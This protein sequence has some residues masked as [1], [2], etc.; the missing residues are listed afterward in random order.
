MS[1]Y[2]SFLSHLHHIYRSGDPRPF[3][4][5]HPELK[6][7]PGPIPNPLPGARPAGLLTG[8][9][10]PLDGPGVLT[11]PL[12]R[13]L[14]NALSLRIGGVSVL[15]SSVEREITSRGWCSRCQ[16]YQSL[17]TKKT[18]HSVPTVLMLNAA[19]NSPEAKQ[20][21]NSPGWLPQ[22]IGV[23]LNQG[24]FFCYQGE[25]LELHLQRGTYNVTVYTLVGLTAEITSAQNQRPHLV[26][27]VN[28]KQSGISSGRCANY[29]SGTFAT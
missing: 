17:A 3:P 14:P 8:V 23:I 19:I 22:E 5:V 9:V 21:W 29:N 13:P 25:D 2:S 18:I 27:F 24:H 26:S 7:L 1:P 10:G 20:L 11:F 28:G 6:V 15:K 12:P 16:R 4:G